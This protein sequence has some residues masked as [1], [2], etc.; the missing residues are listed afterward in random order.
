MSAETNKP[1]TRGLRHILQATGY[2][3]KGLKAAYT[4][5]EAFRLEL[6][7]MVVM[8]PLAIWLGQRAVEWALLISSLL[9]VL[10]AELVNSALEAVVDRVSVEHHELSGR[11]KDIGSAGVFIALANVAVVWGFILYER[12]C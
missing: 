8:V 7:A 2:S 5:E 11:A 3:M 6:L 1:G 4:H 9:L 10:F 12:F